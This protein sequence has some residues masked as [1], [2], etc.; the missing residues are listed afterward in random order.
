MTP[1]ATSGSFERAALFCLDRLLQVAGALSLPG[2]R[3]WVDALRG[4]L[5]VAHGT[6]RRICITV[7]GLAGLWAQGV[8]RLVSE[9]AAQPQMLAVSVVLGLGIAGIDVVAESRAPLL[10]LLALSALTSGLLRPSGACL[11]GLALGLGVP[12]L[13]MVLDYR[14]PYEV[15][16]GDVWYL[17]A[18]AMLL[19]L[20]GR[21]GRLLLGAR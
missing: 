4:E 21:N 18:P 12:A 10:I 11:W 1:R 7:G 19:A 2:S 9:C 5:W 17:V 14:G 13:A 20:L 3:E 16:R 8:A 6:E 15:D